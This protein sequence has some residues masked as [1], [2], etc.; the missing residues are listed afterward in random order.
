MSFLA[1]DSNDNLTDSLLKHPVNDV[2]PN[3]DNIDLSQ[4]LLDEQNFNN[5]KSNVKEWLELDNYI[6]E[7]HKNLKER[8]RIHKDLGDQ[9]SEF[10]VKNNVED[11]S[12]RHGIVR[13]Q[14]SFVKS[15]L[16]QKVIK[17]KLFEMLHD[18][19]NI[20]NDEV[21]TIIKDIFENREKVE[22]TSLKR[23]NL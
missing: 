12:T 13:Y 21:D 23:I 16:S 20:Q 11:L 9:I 19:K 4:Q 3:E 14:K 2:N 7:M 6:R 8:K 22:K 18:H 15:S 10:M 17:E 5:F 1:L